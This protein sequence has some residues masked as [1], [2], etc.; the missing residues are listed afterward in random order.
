MDYAKA[1]RE[2]HEAAENVL[3]LM[4]GSPGPETLKD[5]KEILLKATSYTLDNEADTTHIFGYGPETGDQTFREELAHFLTREYGDTVNSSNLMVTAGATQALHM[6]ASVLFSKDSV[7]FIEDPTYFA[8]CRVLKDDLQMKIVPVPCDADGMNTDV[9]EQVLSEYCPSDEK[10]SSARPFWGMVYTI[11]VYNNPKGNCYSASRCRKLVELARKYDVLVVAED[12]YNLIHFGECSPPARLLSYDKPSDQDYR[13]NVVSIAT[14]SKILA[15]GLRVGW[16]E[17]PQRILSLLCGSYMLWSGGCLNHYAS[18]LAGATLTL[19]L[20]AKHLCH[21]RQVYKKR[22]DAACAV[23]RDSLPEGATF[24]KPQGGFF[25]WI[26]FPEGTDTFK[27][28]QWMINK[29]QVSFMP[30]FWF[31]NQS[32]TSSTNV[33]LVDVRR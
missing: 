31:N 24:R 8:G 10:R 21:I 11:P 26:E 33:Q 4:D 17:A 7:V 27:M 20:L 30:G 19:G 28:M 6:V 1:V 25:V 13:G 9:L 18:K 15:P 32:I 23:L 29:Y 12:I 3:S 5:C 22:N 16:V 2:H 14:F